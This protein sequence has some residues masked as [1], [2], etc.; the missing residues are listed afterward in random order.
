MLKIF[1]SVRDFIYRHFRFRCP[2]CGERQQLRYMN[3]TG[4][5]CFQCFANTMNRQE[6]RR[7]V[8]HADKLQQR[9]GG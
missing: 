1:S 5:I 2:K 7:L 8:R 9:K 4:A 3:G 6:R